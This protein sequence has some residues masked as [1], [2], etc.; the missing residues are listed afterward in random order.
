MSPIS[1]K[2][3]MTSQLKS[4]NITKT[5]TYYVRNPGTGLRQAHKCDGVKPNPCLLIIRS[6]TE[7][8]ISHIQ[9]A[10]QEYILME[11]T[12]PESPIHS[13]LL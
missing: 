9:Q 7:V 5:T 13:D 8:E 6:S 10:K 12:D 11:Q 4:L 2:R 3:T 1:T